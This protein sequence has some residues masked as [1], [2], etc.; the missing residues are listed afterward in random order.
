[1]KRGMAGAGVNCDCRHRIET[2]ISSRQLMPRMSVIPRLSSGPDS[3][4]PAVSTLP[5]PNRKFSAASWPMN[6]PY[7]PDRP[8]PSPE[9]PQLGLDRHAITERQAHRR[10]V[11]NASAARHGRI[12]AAF[13][14]FPVKKGRR[15]C[16]LRR[17]HPA[18]TPPRPTF[19]VTA[20]AFSPMRP[21][22]DRRPCASG[23]PSE[24]VGEGNTPFLMSSL[25]G[26]KF[27]AGWGLLRPVRRP[28]VPLDMGRSTSPLR[29]LSAPRFS[30][31]V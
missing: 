26:E 4:L 23:L 17:N 31:R 8:H 13:S 2:A 15:R 27:F 16:E 19:R 24:T 22:A 25:D 6:S 20:P 3:R 18:V 12:A 21:P 5:F 9:A 14:A 7:F 28:P 11:V 29:T 10:R 30:A 1:M